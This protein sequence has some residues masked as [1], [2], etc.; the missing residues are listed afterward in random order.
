M[1]VVS[2]GE[3]EQ[4]FSN[5][6]LLKMCAGKESYVDLSISLYYIYYLMR[7]YMEELYLYICR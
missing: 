6:M 1:M 3:R 5:C 2:L 4:Y 7:S